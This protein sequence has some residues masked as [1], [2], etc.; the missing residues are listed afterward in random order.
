M[1]SDL[2][3]LSGA[4]LLQAGV[5]GVTL[6]DTGKVETV[7]PEVTEGGTETESGAQVQNETTAEHAGDG[8]DSGRHCN[9]RTVSIEGRRNT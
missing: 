8:G 7:P 1:A 4:L 6:T 2:I 9:G 5:V 3:A